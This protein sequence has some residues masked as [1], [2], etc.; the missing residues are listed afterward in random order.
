MNAVSPPDAGHGPIDLAALASPAVLA[1]PARLYASLR[2]DAGT[3][4][5][6]RFLADVAAID[7]WYAALL[8]CA[9]VPRGDGEALLIEASEHRHLAA[10][11]RITARQVVWLQ[12]D[13]PVLRYAEAAEAGPSPAGS[14]L[15]A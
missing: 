8:S 11:A 1:E 5:P 4:S 9:G 14:L 3:T 2:D 6:W 13:A 15:A 7:I 10:S 12:S